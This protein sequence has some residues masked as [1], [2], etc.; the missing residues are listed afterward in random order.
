V[1][2]EA[3]KRFEVVVKKGTGGALYTECFDDFET[4]ERWL[5]RRWAGLPFH[6]ELIDT[7]CA[8]AIYDHGDSRKRIFT[9]GAVHLLDDVSR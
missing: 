2:A 8:G 7:N 6:V 4:A 5:C 9:I 1:K 3:G